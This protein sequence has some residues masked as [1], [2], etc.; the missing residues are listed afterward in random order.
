MSEPLDPTLEAQKRSERRLGKAIA[1][2]GLC[3]AAGA[4]V[5]AV[6]STVVHG[7]RPQPAP[8]FV[9]LG[10]MAVYGFGLHR[11]LWAPRRDPAGVPRHVRPWLT[12]L[13]TL[14]T[15]WALAQVAGLVA[16]ALRG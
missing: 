10:S 15:W 5:F 3:G 8:T 6:R 4:L 9:F 2:A 13:A 12:V 1:A 16:G 11:A 14:F 7:G